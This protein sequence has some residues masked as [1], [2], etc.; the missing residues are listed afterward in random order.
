MIQIRQMNYS[1]LEEYA[2][3][4][5]ETQ[6]D[7][8]LLEE[9]LINFFLMRLNQDLRFYIFNLIA[10]SDSN[11]VDRDTDILISALNNIKTLQRSQN[12]FKTLVTKFERN[13]S[14]FSAIK[15]RKF[16][17]NK[18]KKQNK[19]FSCEHCKSKSYMSR[20]CYFRHSKL[21]SEN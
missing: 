5:K 1:L 7:Y 2:D 9:A 15:N 6:I 21:K 4:T 13:S 20:R 10:I 19:N 14:K 17:K 12:E 3:A 16:K 18:K 8:S 11:K